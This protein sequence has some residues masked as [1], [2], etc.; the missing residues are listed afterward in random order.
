MYNHDQHEFKNNIKSSCKNKWCDA[1]ALSEVLEKLAC[2][3]VINGNFKRSY[4]YCFVAF[5]FLF[6][7]LFVCCFSFALCSL[8][9]LF[10][11]IF[12][13]SLIF[14]LFVWFFVLFSSVFTQGAL[15]HFC[16][17]CLFCWLFVLCFIFVFRYSVQLLLSFEVN[18]LHQKL[19]ETFVG[20]LSQRENNISWVHNLSMFTAH[21]PVLLLALQYKVVGFNLQASPISEQVQSCNNCLRSSKMPTLTYNRT[22][23]VVIK[24]API[25]NIVHYIFNLRNT[26]GTWYLTIS[27]MISVYYNSFNLYSK[28]IK[29]SCIWK[30]KDCQTLPY[31]RLILLILFL[32]KNVL[33][34]PGYPAKHDCL[35]A[36]G[37]VG[38]H[39]IV[40][41]FY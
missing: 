10:F 5:L 41:Q 32:S 33:L 2:K 24:N 14:A 17:P 16:F 30:K 35:H 26:E 19:E 3:K 18:S 4:N 22:D 39:K 37:N 8:K 27:Y 12:R 38:R 36:S 9:W 28:Q 7:F 1:T 21:F 23:S 11:F 25:L 6:L 20:Y 34:L 40:F 15:F 31:N 13:V 29:R